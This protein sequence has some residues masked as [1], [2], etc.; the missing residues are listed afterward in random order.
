VADRARATVDGRLGA[1]SSEWLAH[2]TMAALDRWQHDTCCRARAGTLAD[3]A[4][5]T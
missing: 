2:F 3:S 4:S 5:T 1:R